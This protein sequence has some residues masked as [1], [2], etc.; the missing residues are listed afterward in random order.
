MQPLRI[1]FAGTPEF[2]CPALRALI[3]RNRPVAVLTQPDRPAGRGRRL[4]HGPVKQLAIE[5]E[6][7]VLQPRSLKPDEVFGQLSKLKPD[8]LVTAAYGLLLPPRVLALPRHGCWNLHASL[9][10]RWRGASPIQQAILAGDRQTGVT[11]MQMDA[12]LDTGDM[13][14]RAETAI[15]AHETAGELH[16]RLAGLAADLL[17]Q[18]LDLLVAGKLP[19]PVAQDPALATHAPLISKRDAAIDWREDAAHIVRMIHAYNPWPVAHG[20][21]GGLDVRVYRA[22]VEPDDGAGNDLDLPPGSL[23]PASGYGRNHDR[24]RVACGRGV[25]AITELQAP[26]RKRVSAREWLNAH[27]DWVG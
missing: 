6:I 18:G 21:L 8:L 12:G 9:L 19:E 5:H 13:L 2:A 1:V 16:D 22:E 24:I 15:G 20:Q 3:E 7:E 4:V 26:G 25:L 23:L 10:P 14:L 27:P 11:L 17:R